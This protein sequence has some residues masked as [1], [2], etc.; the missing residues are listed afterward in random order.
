M[1]GRVSGRGRDGAGGGGGIHPLTLSPPSL[2]FLSS[3]LARLHVALTPDPSCWV[4]LP[5]PL[6]ARLLDGGAPLPLPLELRV[7][8][9]PG[10]EME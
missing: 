7:L 1:R 4:A 8:P 5:P 6:I 3:G 9:P 10:G 2:P